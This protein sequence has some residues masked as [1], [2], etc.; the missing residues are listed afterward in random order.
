MLLG[1]V[2]SDYSD[3]LTNAAM[4]LVASTIASSNDSPLK[5]A[6]IDSGLCED[7]SLSSETSRQGTVVAEFLNCRAED[8]DALCE[9]YDR[10]VRRI[11]KE[12]IDKELLSAN[13]DALEFKLREK[14]FGTLPKGVAFAL[15]AFGSWNYGERPAHGII[16]LEVIEPLRK[17]IEGDYFEKLLLSFTV[18]CPH[19]A[20][21]QMLPDPATAE[22]DAEAERERVNASIGKM[23]E[24]EIDAVNELYER[25]REWQDSEDSPENLDTLPTLSLSDVTSQPRT[26]TPSLYEIDGARYASTSPPT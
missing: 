14:D 7:F 2:Y 17:L 23:T 20:R 21:L 10:E 12:G 25:L 18:D 22:K 16:S 3:S 19:R 24:E 13:L 15:A 26:L 8:F 4:S 11:A 1:T 6:I 5:K 9:L